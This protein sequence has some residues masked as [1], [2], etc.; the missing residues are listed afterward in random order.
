[1]Y[2]A[3]LASYHILRDEKADELYGRTYDE[4]D[5]DRQKKIKQLIPL[6]ISEAEPTEFGEEES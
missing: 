2:D 5:K 6:I 3:L 1:M 4:L